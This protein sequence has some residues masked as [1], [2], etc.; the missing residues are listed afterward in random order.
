MRRTLCLAAVV[1]ALVCAPQIA[2]VAQDGPQ[3]GRSDDCANAASGQ[4]SSDKCRSSTDRGRAKND[5]TKNDRGWRAT[6][7]KDKSSGGTRDRNKS[8]Q[9]RNTFEAPNTQPSGTA[10]Q[11][12]GNANAQQGG[13]KQNSGLQQPAGGAPLSGQPKKSGGVQ[14]PLDQKSE[15]VAADTLSLEGDEQHRAFRDIT[16][17]AMKSKAP[18]GF[19]ARVGGVVSSQIAT[20]PIPGTTA[21]K[22]PAL[23][24]YHYALLDGNKLLIVNPNDKKIALIVTR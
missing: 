24:P 13:A 16:G 15:S 11:Q 12:R 8:G 19:N 2:A 18:S 6:N 14:T 23:R 5:R 1:V 20:H 17:F 21:A 9:I 10:S 7:D 4:H 22:V 3:P